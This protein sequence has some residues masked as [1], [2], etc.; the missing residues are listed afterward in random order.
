MGQ[1]R[2]PSKSWVFKTRFS[3]KVRKNGQQKV[4][5]EYKLC[6]IIYKMGSAPSF[7]KPYLCIQ[8]SLQYPLKICSSTSHKFH[9]PIPPLL[10]CKII[11]TISSKTLFLY[12]S[13]T[14]HHPTVHK[15]NFSPTWP[16][17]PMHA[18]PTDQ[19][20]GECCEDQHCLISLFFYR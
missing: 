12:T 15:K 2:Y 17:K 1:I 11:L 5:L 3:F 8:P 10:F 4:Y 14:I 7:S 19:V 16:T 6:W 9:L 13:A 20:A 18:G